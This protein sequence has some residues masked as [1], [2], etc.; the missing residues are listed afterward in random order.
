MSPL[1]RLRRIETS[2]TPRQAVL[3]WLKEAQQ[4][5]FLGYTEKSLSSTMHEAPRARL[6]E[7]VGKAVRE[8]LC[9]QGMKR[10]LI[11][12][13]EREARKQTDFLIILIRNLHWEVHEECTLDAPY[14]VLLY[15]KFKRMLEHYT[16]RAAKFDPE[17]WEIWRAILI[18]RLTRMRQLSETVV[19]ISERY[20]DGHPLLFP[21]EANTLDNNI[22]AL[23]KLTKHYNS[24]EG[25]LPA[26]TTIDVEALAS[27]IREQL[28]AQIAERVVHA[29]ATTLEDFGELEA[30]WKL[31]EPLAL[32]ELKRLRASREKGGD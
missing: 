27:S 22:D 17:I 14:I 15:E 8:S 32:A 5:G 23:E 26:W 12:P 20:F 29:K 10:E 16:Q 19:A 13:A 7:M 24:L 18:R 4:L 31:T 30:S 25:G 11:L 9:E 2:L 6:T 1:Q 3:L 21:E 28:S